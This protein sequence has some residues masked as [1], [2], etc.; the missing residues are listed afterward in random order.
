ML[1]DS[2]DLRVDSLDARAEVAFQADGSGIPL[3]RSVNE[4]VDLSLDVAGSF[5]V[6]ESL[7]RGGLVKTV[8][9]GDLPGAGCCCRVPQKAKDGVLNLVGIVQGEALCHAGEELFV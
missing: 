8:E 1:A 4:S 2:S 3:K 5:C 6:G 9:I 7:I